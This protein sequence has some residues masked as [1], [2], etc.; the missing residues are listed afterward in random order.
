MC[1]CWGMCWHLVSR[2]GWWGGNGSRVKSTVLC[3]KGQFCIVLYSIQEQGSPGFLV[4]GRLFPRP[5]HD[6]LKSEDMWAFYRGSAVPL[7][8]RNAGR[9]FLSSL[10]LSLDHN[11]FCVQQLSY[12]LELACMMLWI[13]VLLFLNYLETI[14]A[15]QRQLFE[16][17]F[18]Y[19]F[20]ENILLP[21]F[22]G[23]TLTVLQH[24]YCPTLD[25]QSI[26]PLGQCFL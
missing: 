23:T 22:A 24:L 4:S 7:I 2:N 12:S 26:G 6:D 19:L 11:Q 15:T 8:F 18:A 9:F 21:F 10:I 5:R 14:W 17:L 3:S 1:Q 20:T 13:V 16:L 25:F